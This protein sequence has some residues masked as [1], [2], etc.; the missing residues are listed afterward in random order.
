MVTLVLEY[1]IRKF[2]TT[3][4]LA[5]NDDEEDQLAKGEGYLNK[6]LQ[7]VPAYVENGRIIG[8]RFTEDKSQIVV[9]AQM[10]VPAS[11]A[12]DALLYLDRFRGEIPDAGSLRVVEVRKQ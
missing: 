12:G 8:S 1:P 7:A 5:N 11:S 6:L 9:R 3:K 4:I 2:I 10:A